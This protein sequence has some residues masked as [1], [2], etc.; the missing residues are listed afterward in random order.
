M[1]ASFSTNTLDKE[2]MEGND[3]TIEHNEDGYPLIPV[4]ALDLRLS[5]K[6]A[7]IRLYMGSAR[8]MCIFVHVIYQL[9]MHN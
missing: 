6:K 5:R 7:I 2:D 8:R 4:D 3:T 9:L 1:T